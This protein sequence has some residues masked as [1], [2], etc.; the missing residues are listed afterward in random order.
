M[1]AQEIVVPASTAD[2]R[3]ER[4]TEKHAKQKAPPMYP[5]V[6]STHSSAMNPLGNVYAEGDPE[7]QDKHL[8][9]LDPIIVEGDGYLYGIKSA[10]IVELKEEVR[11]NDFF[12][13]FS[14]PSHSVALTAAG[15]VLLLLMLAAC[16]R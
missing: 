12:A 15:Q 3:K 16:A 14:G 8:Q 1:A 9:P 4:L 13:I 2:K 6:L 7:Y 5:D 10:Q 11:G